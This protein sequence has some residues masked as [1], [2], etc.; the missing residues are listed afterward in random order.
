MLVS[1]YPHKSWALEI[2]SPPPQCINN[3]HKPNKPS[4]KSGWRKMVSFQGINISHQ[5]GKGKSSTQKCHFGGD[6]FVP[7]RVSFQSFTWNWN[8]KSVLKNAIAETT[9]PLLFFRARDSGSSRQSVSP[10]ETVHA[11][12]SG[13][14]VASKGQ[15]KCGLQFFWGVTFSSWWFQPTWK[16]LVKMDVFFRK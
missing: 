2:G 11:L 7:W 8:L 1:Q 16:I 15:V 12:G 6:M 4:R 10:C 3:G 13:F 14:R 5:T 9:S